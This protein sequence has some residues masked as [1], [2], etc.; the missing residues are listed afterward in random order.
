MSAGKIQETT[1]FGRLLKVQDSIGERYVKYRAGNKLCVVLWSIKK[2]NLN[3][4]SS[5]FVIYHM[6][7]AYTYYLI[8]FFDGDLLLSNKS[9]QQP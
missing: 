3:T 1:V 9:F 6:I 4:S 8:L 2:T 5:G 7:Y